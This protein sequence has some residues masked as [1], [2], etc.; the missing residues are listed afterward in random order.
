MPPSSGIVDA[1]LERILSRRINDRYPLSAAWK[2]PAFKWP[3]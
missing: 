1:D 3:I 2:L